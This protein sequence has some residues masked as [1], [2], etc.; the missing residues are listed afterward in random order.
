MLVIIVISL[1][2]RVCVWM[3]VCSVDICLHSHFHQMTHESLII[4]AAY[5]PRYTTLDT[6]RTFPA[7]VAQLLIL[8]VV[9]GAQH[10][11]I[12]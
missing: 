3:V 5:V 10:V 11:C 9:L 8:S 12:E 1:F 4:T 2:A 6:A 7:A